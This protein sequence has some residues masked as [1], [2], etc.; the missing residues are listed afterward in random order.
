MFIMIY[1]DKI[2]DSVKRHLMQNHDKISNNP[3]CLR[4]AKRSVTN[5]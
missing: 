2:P 1:F 3:L 5:S 4:A